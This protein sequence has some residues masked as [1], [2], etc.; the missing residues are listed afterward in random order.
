MRHIN[1]PECKIKVHEAKEQMSSRGCSE[2]KTLKQWRAILTSPVSRVIRHEITS[3]V[4]YD[5]TT[6]NDSLFGRDNRSSNLRWAHFC[7][8][9]RGL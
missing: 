3:R 6:N 2:N 1:L 7:H 8:V 9:R 5:N 4:S